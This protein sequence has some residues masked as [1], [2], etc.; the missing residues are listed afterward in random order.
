[1]ATK[2][3]S[4]GV[5][6]AAAA[7]VI[8]IASLVVG[9]HDAARRG[10]G[11]Y[12]ASFGGSTYETS[13]TL[14]LDYRINNREPSSSVP[15]AVQQAGSLLRSHR[16]DGFKIKVGNGEYGTRRKLAPT[17]DRVRDLLA[18]TGDGFNMRVKASDGYTL[19]IVVF[20]ADPRAFMSTNGNDQIDL[21][22]GTVVEK[23]PSVRNNGILVCK[24]IA[25]SSSW[26][27]HAYA[28]AVD[29]NGPGAWGSAGNVALLDDVVAYVTALTNQGLLPVSQI[30]WRNWPNHY[31]G[32]AHF[33]GAP[34]RYGTPNCAR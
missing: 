32:H 26:S 9:S 21:I 5:A 11:E 23:F 30:G 29:F 7:A 33:S 14:D 10:G 12:N 17:L 8:A 22:V 19:T 1:M 6:A 25:G 4:T 2:R 18:G 3:R 13:A 27:Q 31:P 20:D 16:E 34:L 24:H 15:E 28:N